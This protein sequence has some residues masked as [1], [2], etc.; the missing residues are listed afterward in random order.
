MWH[1]QFINCISK[2]LGET[3]PTVCFFKTSEPFDHFTVSRLVSILLPHPLQQKGYNT[4][5]SAIQWHIKCFQRRSYPKQDKKQQRIGSNSFYSNTSYGF[6]YKKTA[7]VNFLLKFM[8]RK[9]SA[10]KAYAYW[11]LL[12]FLTPVT[13]K[14]LF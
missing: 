8:K 14:K 12:S 11:M 10:E 2:L 5:P 7:S 4:S 1:Y 3:R 9:T 6:E 13:Y